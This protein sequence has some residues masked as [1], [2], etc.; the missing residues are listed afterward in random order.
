MACEMY[1]NEIPLKEGAKE[2]L[3]ILKE[4]KLP[5]GIATSNSRE[6]TNACLDAPWDRGIFS[7][8]LYLQ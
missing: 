5:L 7:V 2:F 3:D 8:Y 6:L 1:M 4:K